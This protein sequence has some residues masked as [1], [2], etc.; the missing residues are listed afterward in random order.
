MH[1]R[2]H[3]RSVHKTA[4]SI[5][6]IDPTAQAYLKD[7][8][9]KVPVPNNPNDPRGSIATIV[10]QVSTTKRFQDTRTPLTVWFRAMWWITHQK[11]GISA[12]GLQRTL[13]LGSYQTA[14]ACLHKL[15]H[16]MVRPGR[17]RLSGAVEVDEA[18]PG[19]L[20]MGVHGRQMETKALIVV[21]AEEDGKG[22][23]RR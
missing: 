7:I 23:G 2:Q 20:E 16:A 13:G 14:W 5:S 21:A 4:T 8:I 10:E 6:N 18:W 3:Q 11:N 17:E 22:F 12:L 15:R 1:Q 9:N 19:G